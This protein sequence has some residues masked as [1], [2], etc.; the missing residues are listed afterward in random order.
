FASTFCAPHMNQ[1]FITPIPKVDHPELINQFRS[2]KPLQY[3]VE[4]FYNNYYRDS[5]LT[6]AASL[7]LTKAASSLG[8]RERRLPIF[9]SFTPVHK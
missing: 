6:W 4:D 7:V 8:E 9:S 5:Y 2:C 3:H 1:T